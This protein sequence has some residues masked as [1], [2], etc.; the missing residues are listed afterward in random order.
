MNALAHVIVTEGL[1]D[2]AFVAER[3]DPKAFA[4]GGEFIREAR[5]SPERW[6]GRDRRARR[7]A[8]RR[9]AALRHRRQRRDLLRPRRHRA[10]PGLDD[11]HGH[12]QPRDG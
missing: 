5:N 1:E 11:G 10:Q 2:E 12:R 6:R 9:G 7:D 4:S 3:C 8:A